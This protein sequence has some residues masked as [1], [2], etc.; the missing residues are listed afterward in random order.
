[1]KK[2]KRFKFLEQMS[3]G[4]VADFGI[5]YADE[6]KWTSNERTS[7]RRCVATT[8]TGD[9]WNGRG[10]QSLCKQSLPRFLHSLENDC[11]IVTER[12]LTRKRLLSV[13]LYD[14][15]FDNQC[16]S[17]R[18]SQVSNSRLLTWFFL[19]FC[20]VTSHSTSHDTRY[21]ISEWQRMFHRI[22]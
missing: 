12:L 16:G 22:H 7:V 18:P 15:R 4:F 21:C 5:S 20:C 14:W 13:V 8:R 11:Y 10:E 2:V 1:M 6:E 3:H 19:G 17:H 9:L